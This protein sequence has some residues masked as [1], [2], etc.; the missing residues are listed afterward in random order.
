MRE[1]ITALKASNRNA[2]SDI[3]REL[4]V[5]GL[6]R[7]ADEL[8]TSTLLNVNREFRASIHNFLEALNYLRLVTKVPS[9]AVLV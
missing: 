1:E 7:G 4:F 9:G 5:L 8:E 6:H 3:E 2:H